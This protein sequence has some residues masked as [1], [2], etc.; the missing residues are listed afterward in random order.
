MNIEYKK[1]ESKYLINKHKINNSLLFLIADKVHTK[2]KILRN[3]ILR[4][5]HIINM[6]RLHLGQTTYL[7]GKKKMYVWDTK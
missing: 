3:V 5:C 4:T 2:N 1:N 6:G 7:L